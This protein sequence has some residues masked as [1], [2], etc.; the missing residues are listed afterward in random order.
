M[1][2]ATEVADQQRAFLR[3]YY[4]Q[5]LQKTEDLTEQACCV[6]STFR[7]HASTIA[8]LPDEVVTR[9]YGCGC[10]IPEDDLTGLTCLDLGS[11]AG[12][13]AFLL[14]RLVGSKGHV[15]GLDMTDEQ[16]DVARRNAPAV[17]KAFGHCK[18]NTTFHKGM[19]ETAE[20]IESNSVDLVISD[21][22]VNL[23]PRKDLVFQTIHRVL[24]DGG[25]LY[26]SDIVADRRIP[27]EIA[28][29]PRLHA[30]CL[31]GALY[32][33]D[34]YDLL[35]ETGFV[36]T[37][38][39]ERRVLQTEVLGQ[40]IVFSSIT[41]RA[42]KFATPLDRRCEDYG[43]FATYTGAFSRTPARFH[44]DDSHVFERDRP[45]PVCRNTAR[46]LSETRLA[47]G[48]RVTE[49]VQH[50]GLFQR[51]PRAAP[52]NGESPA[53]GN[54]KPAAVV[55]AASSEAKDGPSSTPCC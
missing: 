15:H 35:A 26:I 3:E 40:P 33:H 55:K 53:P 18:P 10:P 38:V 43:Q 1:S 14:A 6:E 49:P 20:P 4:G 31:G 7:R 22:V 50:F 36:D 23:S 5:T 28:N 13:D 51:G 17:A 47:R 44:Y 45:T 19:I 12:V 37:R 34:L 52:S 11:G 21:C 42:Q 27:D 8:L 29:D 54:P 25:E 32:E 41:I 2:P 39:V 48:F 30:E 46:M 24:K 16:L 9:H